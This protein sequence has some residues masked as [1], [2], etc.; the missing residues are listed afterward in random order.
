[1]M[2]FYDKE[3]NIEIASFWDSDWIVRI[4]DRTNGYTAE[5]PLCEIHEI[6]DWLEEKYAELYANR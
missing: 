2:K 1:M 5:S 6:A 4:G 3:Q